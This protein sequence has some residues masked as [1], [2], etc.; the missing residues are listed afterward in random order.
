MALAKLFSD[1][2]TQVRSVYEGVKNDDSIECIGSCYTK[3]GVL[4]RIK[5]KKEGR[6]FHFKVQLES[7][8]ERNDFKSVT[9]DSRGAVV[10]CLEDGMKIIELVR[11][12]VTEIIDTWI[13]DPVS[14]TLQKPDHREE[15]A[16]R[17]NKYSD[18]PDLSC[19]ACGDPTMTALECG[20]RL[21]ICCCPEIFDG[22]HE[23][24]CC[25]CNEELGGLG[26]EFKPLKRPR[27]M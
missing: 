17:L 13:A 24:Y 14:G 11:Q 6:W 1:F 4:C 12:E 7:I 18:Q 15:V 10:D 26:L 8:F 25:F 23:D 9:N 27:K 2:T 3:D 19:N 16:R 5:L 21:C 22:G 20:C